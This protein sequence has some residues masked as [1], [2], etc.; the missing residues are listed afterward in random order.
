M[1]THLQPIGY[2]TWESGLFSKKI[3][4]NILNEFESIVNIM[5]NNGEISTTLKIKKLSF[6]QNAI[7]G[8]FSMDTFI[9]VEEIYSGMEKNNSLGVSEYDKKITV[10]GI[11]MNLLMSFDGFP[12][13]F[14]ADNSNK[15][16]PIG[17]FPKSSGNIS[18]NPAQVY[19]A[20][21]WKFHSMGLLSAFKGI[22]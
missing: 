10:N 6:I 20:D 12:Q 14:V 8:G 13:I 19:D 21:F 2:F 15:F 5:F 16:I 9:E 4:V 17:A 18:C 7:I 11:E 3:S 1:R 22:N